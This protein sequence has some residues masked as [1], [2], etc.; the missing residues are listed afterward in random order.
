MGLLYGAKLA[1]LN[2][3]GVNKFTAGITRQLEAETAS[4]NT[5]YQWRSGMYQ[6]QGDGN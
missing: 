2:F 6:P 3:C 4:E 1:S 5:T